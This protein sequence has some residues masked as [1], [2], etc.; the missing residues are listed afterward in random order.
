MPTCKRILGHFSIK[1]MCFRSESSSN[2]DFIALSLMKF[3]FSKT[4]NMEKE[5][6]SPGVSRKLYRDQLVT[7][8]DLEEFKQD[9]LLAL[10]RL[11]KDNVEKPPKKWLKSREVKMM[12]KISESTLFSLRING[13]LPYTKIGNIIYYNS[14]EVEEVLSG[15]RKRPPGG[16]RPVKRMDRG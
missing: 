3:M 11:L 9:L 6:H 1:R 2:T 13:T 5:S 12:L 10:V 15:K 14:D 4:I 8:E 7:R 16:I